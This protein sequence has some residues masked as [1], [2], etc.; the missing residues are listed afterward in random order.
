[1]FD[2]GGKVNYADFLCHLRGNCDAERMEII[3][4]AYAKINTSGTVTLDN[5]A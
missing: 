2:N 1:M 3:K 4:K 5:I